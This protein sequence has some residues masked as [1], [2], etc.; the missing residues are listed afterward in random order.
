MFRKFW[1]DRRG[2]YALM[3]AAA[4]VPIMGGLAIAVDY[5]E[6]SKQRQ[7]TLNALDAAGIA[8]ARRIQEG[9]TDDEAKLYAKNFFEAN[10]G[11]VEPK[12]TTLSIVLPNYNVGAGTLK[13]SAGLK[14]KPYFFPTFAA[15]LGKSTTGTTDLDFAATSEIKMQDTI[16]LSLVLDNS[17]SMSQLGHGSSK[18]RMDLLKDAAKQL[19]DAMS[20]TASQMKQISKPVQIGLVP[21][22]AS[23]NVGPDKETAS[24]MDT[25]G[26]S[27]VHHE[28][29]DWSTMPSGYSVT[30]TAGIY[31]KTGNS[32]GTQ[33]GEKVTRFTLFKEMK[34][35]TASGNNSPKANYT[36]WQGCVE[37]RPSPYDVND[38]SPSNTVPAT[39]FVPM[40]APD[41]PS[42]AVNDWY[43]FRY[44]RV[45]YYW[46][47]VLGNGYSGLQKQGYMGKYFDIPSGGYVAPYRTA[48]AGMDEGPNFMCTTSAIT[49]LTDI[50]AAAGAT[51]IKNAIDAMQPNGA[52][53]VP[54]GMAWGWRVV[55]SGAPFTEG[56]PETQKGND[57]VVIVI[58][59][60]A[61]TYY[62]PGF[63]NAGDPAGNQ[64]AYSNLGYVGKTTPGYTTSRM[65]QGTTV[66]KT[67]YSEA[68]YTVAM[69][70][71]FDALCANAKTAGIIVMTVAV[72][73]D[74]NNA[75]EKK[76]ADELKA[77]ASPSKF[78]KDASGN[79]EQNFWNTTGGDLST[80]FKAIANELSNLRIVG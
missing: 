28:N 8:T 56:R 66:S 42:S 36:S 70:Q 16:E 1:N 73:L 37:A 3:T 59:D 39:L 14:Y 71:H 2:N 13:L 78:R 35:Y 22:A 20:G 29:F 4:I 32:W 54:E 41:E 31:Y 33:K 25:N 9:A 27:P 23:V 58:T 60:G 50:S 40:F 30:P 45:D 55:S 11:S 67:T 43:L 44:N 47:D 46:S 7:E 79:P 12:N 49:P 65:F 76:Q 72:D 24:W 19:V 5:G 53:N 61:N 57:K 52:T 38:T 34:Y 69:N 75:T 17:G 15:L 62:T 77:C 18:V 6:M 74:M 48:P 68:N 21:F 26:I 10:L 51:A 80:T 63:F 64:S